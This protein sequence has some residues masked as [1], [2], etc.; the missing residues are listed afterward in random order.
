MMWLG[1]YLLF[2]PIIATLQWIPFV[3][4]LIA[5]GVS[6]VVLIFTFLTAVIFT[7][8]TIGLAWLYYRPLYGLAF[9]SIVV[10]G[11]GILFLT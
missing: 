10:I 9:L 7:S 5:Q 4:M 11:V 3:G 1:Q 2:A 8:L 6:C